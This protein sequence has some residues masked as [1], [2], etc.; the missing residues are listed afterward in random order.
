MTDHSL[1]RSETQQLQDVTAVL[2]I[3]HGS[4][5][6]AANQDLVDLAARLADWKVYPIVEAAFLELAPPDIPQGI[7]RCVQRGAR[8]VL[9]I[10]Y[11]LSLGIHMI[12]D[13]A[14]ARQEAEEAYP[15]VHFVLGRPLGP[16]ALLDDLVKQRIREADTSQGVIRA[17]SPR[18]D[19]ERD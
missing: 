12:R 9:L 15:G 6:R 19:R 4:R 11:F 8:R 2:L 7:A 1:D 10:P 5:H 17:A 3:A 18:A 16:D 14:S 13:L